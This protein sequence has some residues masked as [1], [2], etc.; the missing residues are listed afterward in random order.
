MPSTSVQADAENLR[1][2]DREPGHARLCA[3]GLATIASI[4]GYLHGVFLH[5]D[6]QK[7]EKMLH[8]LDQSSR[9]L[10]GPKELI[11]YRRLNIHPPALV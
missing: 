11:R 3:G 8:V 4:T 9:Y 6:V 10:S 5:Q 7:C 2:D 1:R